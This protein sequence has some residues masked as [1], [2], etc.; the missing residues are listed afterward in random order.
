[1]RHF[2]WSHFI[3]LASL[4]VAFYW[5]GASGIFIAALLILMEVSFSCDNAVV[6][7][8]VLKGME[9]KWQDRFLTWGILIAVFGVRLVFPILIVALAT[10]LG[11]SEVVRM[12]LND[13]DNYTHYLH[14]SHAQIAAFGGMFLLM[15]FL[16][17]LFDEARELH[18]LGDVEEKL[19]KLGKLESVEVITAMGL[20]LVLQHFLPEEKKHAVLLAGSIGVVLYV[21]VSSV[22]ALLSGGNQ[23][24]GH[25]MARTVGY[26]GLMGFIYLNI[27]DAS[28][29]LD[30]VIGAFAISRDIV[31]IM[32]GLGAGALYV[33]SMTI[34]LVRKGTLDEY[35]FLE[36]GAHYGIGALSL[37]MLVTISTPVPE[38]I[39]GLVGAGFILL[40][41]YSSIQHN[42]R[43]GII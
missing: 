39:T 32:L 33:R 8:V 4:A 31:I 36:H 5:A 40:S 26:S 38:Y 28:F 14:E 15:V 9:K 7:A 3:A 2:F 23:Q 6:N 21:A 37:I 22:T 18:W 19:A 24:S 17:F 20:L 42:K 11:M 30:G 10:G 27:L 1:M 25:D 35:V 16:K 41:L 13:P 34:Y 12:S 43:K 29:S